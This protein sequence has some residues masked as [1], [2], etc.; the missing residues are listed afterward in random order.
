M[1]PLRLVAMLESLMRHITACRNVSLPGRRFPLRLGA[2]TVGWITGDGIGL[3]A[4]AAPQ[5]ETSDAGI[6]LS[7]ATSFEAMADALAA[8]GVVRCRAERFA[9]RAAPDAPELARIDRG[10]LPFLGVWSEGVHLNG[11]VRRRDGIFIWI[12]ERAADRVLDPGKL[13]HLVAGG[14]PAGLSPAATLAKEAT[15]EAAIPLA[16]VRSAVPVGR[17]IYTM[18]RPEGLR[19]DRLHCYDLWLPEGFLPRPADGEVASFALWPL[20]RVLEVLCETDRFKFNVALVL[21]DLFLRL[22]VIDPTSREGRVL[23]A[24]IADMRPA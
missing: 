9:V 13:D 21:I 5:A 19:R 6:G 15:E 7:D 16:F 23:S 24:A 2:A 12:A 22:G 11:L 20:A 3:V 17:M 18:E 14:I 4:E 8:R 1:L 10:A